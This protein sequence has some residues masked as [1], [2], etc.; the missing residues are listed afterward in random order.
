MILGHAL[1]FGS[2]PIGILLFD[3]VEELDAVG[4]WEVF[5]FVTTWPDDGWQVLCFAADGL[6]DLW[7]QGTDAIVPQHATADLPPLDVLLHPGGRG[8]RPMLTDGGHRHWI[9]EQRAAVSLMTSVCTGSLVYARTVRAADRLAMHQPTGL[10]SITRPAPPNA[11]S[12]A[13]TGNEY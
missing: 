1:Y 11:A 4:P 7:R 3:G 9:R 6:R 2:T 12:K 13:K 8:T 5:G 10:P